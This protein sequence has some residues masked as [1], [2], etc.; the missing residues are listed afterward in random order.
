MS[1]SMSQK[2][3]QE[4]EEDRRNLR[5]ILGN[6]DGMVYRCKN[7]EDYTMEF[8]NEGAYILTGYTAEMFTS[9]KVSFGKELIYAPDLA[10]VQ[11]VIDTALEDELPFTLEYRIQCADG[12]IV[13]VTERGKGIF[14][15]GNLLYLEGYIADINHLKT[16]EAELQL[17]NGELTVS[18]EELLQQQEEIITQRDYIELKNFLNH[19]QQYPLEE[20]AQHINQEL[21]A[22]QQEETQRDDMTLIGIQL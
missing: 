9:G 14:D 2:E 12:R 10:H 20:Q 13:W 22:Y 19:I 21:D 1:N 8:V 3:L 5:T 15:Q 11:E 17:A 18:K 7:D 4:L 16:V 6:L